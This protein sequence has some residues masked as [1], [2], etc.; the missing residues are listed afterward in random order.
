MDSDTVRRKIRERLD[1]GMLPRAVPPLLK[2]GPPQVSAPPTQIKADTAI[3]LARCAGCDEA[4]AQVAV[5]V[6][7]GSVLRFHGRCHRIWEE[8]CQSTRG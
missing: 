4:G 3:G 6:P 2:A 7:D 1:A 5:R 8:E